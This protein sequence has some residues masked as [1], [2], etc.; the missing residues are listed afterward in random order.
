MK[1]SVKMCFKIILKVTK[2]QGSI[3][4]LEDT[5]LEKPQWW[6]GGGG[7]QFDSPTPPPPAVLGIKLV[8]SPFL[9]IL[10]EKNVFYSIQYKNLL[11]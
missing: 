1:F 5:F 10:T 7:D 9:T 2:N 6:V 4:S 11:K 8:V 3:L